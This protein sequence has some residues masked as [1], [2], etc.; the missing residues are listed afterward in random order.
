MLT[1]LLLIGNILVLLG[2]FFQLDSIER[3][4]IAVKKRGP[5]R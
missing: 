3:H 1:D 5:Q 4:I 2:V